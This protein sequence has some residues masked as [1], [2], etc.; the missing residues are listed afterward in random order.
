MT[1]KNNRKDTAQNGVY[2]VYKDGS[3]KPFTGDNKTSDAKDVKYIGVVYDGH[4]FCVSLKH[5]GS[6]PLREIVDYSRPYNDPH[7]VDFA[8]AILGWDCVEKTKYIQKVGTSIPLE[9]GEYIP[10]LPM[11][12][13]MSSLLHPLSRAMKFVGGELFKFGS[14]WS[15]AERDCFEGYTLDMS[16]GEIEV[17]S[18][19]N[20]CHIR[21][22][23][24]FD[25][26][27]VK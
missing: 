12:A 16:D 20:R 4:A 13:V 1:E 27:D 11:L 17:D 25:I 21:P 14:Y 7:F 19:N 5:L 26:V 8:E 15:C 18:K 9:D 24:L 3:Y 6:F 23:A 10:S 2:L 22:V